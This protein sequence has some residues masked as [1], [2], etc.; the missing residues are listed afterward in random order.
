MLKM[1]YLNPE[2]QKTIWN[3]PG[4]FGT[5]PN[6]DNAR[7]R[8]IS[9]CPYIEGAMLATIYKT[10]STISVLCF[11]C[12]CTIKRKEKQQNHVYDV[13]RHL[14]GTILPFISL[15]VLLVLKTN[16]A[17][18]ESLRSF[19]TLTHSLIYNFIVFGKV[20]LRSLQ[21]YPFLVCED[22]TEWM[23]PLSHF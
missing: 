7:A 2:K 11:C 15:S 14:D 21:Y 13:E 4:S 5:P 23:Q 22:A 18:E 1:S 8:F 17:R 3:L 6:N 10:T 12:S 9:S 19:T 16:E 20:P